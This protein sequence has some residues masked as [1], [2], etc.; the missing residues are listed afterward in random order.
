LPKEWR[1]QPNAFDERG[2]L[3]SL[4]ELVSFALAI[5][6]STHSLF[7]SD[8]VVMPF[9]IFRVQLNTCRMR[10]FKEFP[11]ATSGE[12]VYETK[13]AAQLVQVLTHC[14]QSVIL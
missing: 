1:A 10:L 14:H 8:C 5:S 4:A 7:E 11:P 12:P 2:L 13:V 9:G 6:S 3:H